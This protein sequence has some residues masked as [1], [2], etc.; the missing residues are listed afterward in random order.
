MNL[1]TNPHTYPNSSVRQFNKIIITRYE[2]HSI[3]V[4]DFG[5][6]APVDFNQKEQ[7]YNWEL[8]Y[9]EMYAGGKYNTDGDNYAFSLGL[10]GLG[11]FILAD[12]LKMPCVK[13]PF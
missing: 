3:E 2:D 10:N 4:Q 9:C 6:G 5:R 13:G 1:P 7:R 11:D 8:L 12:F